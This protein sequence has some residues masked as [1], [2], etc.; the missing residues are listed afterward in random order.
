MIFKEGIMRNALF[1]KFTQ[2]V[3]LKYKLLST[4]N[5]GIFE[6]TENDRYWGDG[7]RNRDGLN[8]LG[9]ML[10]EL[11]KMLMEEEKTKLM[12]KYYYYYY[13]QKW[14]VPGLEVLRQFDDLIDFG[15]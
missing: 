6:H 14:V 8:K 1:H 9:I 15:N 10:Q 5:V 11:R 2:H 7:G 12:N 13:S 4:G 3:K